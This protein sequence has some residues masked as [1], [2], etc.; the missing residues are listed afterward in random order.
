M[1]RDDIK[2]MVKS[3][4]AQGFVQVLGDLLEGR[5]QGGREVRKIRPEQV[6]IRALW[7]A[8]VGPVEE[9]LPSMRAAGRFNFVDIQEAVETTAFPS[10]TG[11]LIASKVIEAYN[12]PGYIGDRLVTV[13]PSKLKSER[14]VGFTSLEGPKEVPEGMPYEESSFAEKYV[15]T[16]TAKKGRI[17]ELTEEAI[18]QD[19][20]G[21]ILLRASRLGEMTRLERE[22]TILSG[23]IDVGSGAVGYKDVYRPTGVAEALYVASN[24]NLL[25]AT[26]LVDWTDIDEVLRYHAEN[27]KDDRAVA[28]EQRPL[29]WMPRQILTARRLAGTSARVL[30][31]T[32][33]RSVSGNETVITQ[34]PVN[35]IAPGLEALA[36][37]LL[38]FLATVTGSRYTV[39]TGWFLGDFPRQFVWQEIW[40]LQ[41]F[42]SRQDDEAAFRR[43]VV[44]RFK[45]RYWGGIAAIDERQVIKVT[46]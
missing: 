3:L 28:G 21:Q 13:M 32:E 5:D 31:A 11:V 22:E 42:R 35:V 38:D 17:L 25:T 6:S 8:C 44:A 27:V 34:N 24:N 1:R 14:I 19:Q 23:V 26:A 7:E 29:P 15:T 9:T 46:A 41:T 43:D 10:A 16:E 4:G 20:T 36:S 45:V 2:A 40:P 18:F 12:Q 30:N 37:P 39:A 33:H